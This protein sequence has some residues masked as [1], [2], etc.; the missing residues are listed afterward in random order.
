MNEFCTAI[1]NHDVTMKSLTEARS[2]WSH[3]WTSYSPEIGNQ[4]AI[5]DKIDLNMLP[6][7]LVQKVQQSWSLVRELQ[8]KNDKSKRSY[9]EDDSDREEPARRKKPSKQQRANQKK[10]AAAKKAAGDKAKGGGWKA[11]NPKK[12][13]RK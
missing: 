2:S 5:G 12:K 11:W 1:R 13:T 3:Y 4:K 6:P 10:A 9:V 7:D 8:S